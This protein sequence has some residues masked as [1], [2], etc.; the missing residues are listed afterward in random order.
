MER[1]IYHQ[2]IEINRTHLC[3]HYKTT[4]A[5]V[6][7]DISC[8]ETDVLRRECLEEVS[9][10]LVR[11]RLDWRSV[12]D[13][14]ALL[15]TSSDGKFG[16]DS[17]SSRSMRRHQNAFIA[18]DTRC[19]DKLEGVELERICSCWWVEAL[20]FGDGNVRIVWWD[21]D[22]VSHRMDNLH[23]ALL[24]I[25][26]EPFCRLHFTLDFGRYLID[27]HR[28]LSWDENVR[29]L[30]NRSILVRY[31]R[32]RFPWVFGLS[33]QRRHRIVH[34]YIVLIVDTR[35]LASRLG[36]RRP[37]LRRTLLA[38]PLRARC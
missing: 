1:R 3:S 38:V 5:G 37:T 9:V 13:T 31:L 10:L 35:S 26:S 21:S 25:A 12:D 36:C 2:N 17:L 15:Q 18:L 28:R 33:F 8:H 30:D 4:G 27:S 22:L 23:L 24:T 34:L 11:K 16:D 20:V 19:S 14:L 29:G 6:D 32:E 7:G